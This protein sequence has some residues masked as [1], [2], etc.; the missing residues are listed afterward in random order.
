MPPLFSVNI[1]AR[2]KMEGLVSATAKKVFKKDAKR[3]QDILRQRMGGGGGGRKLCQ[4]KYTVGGFMY[5]TTYHAQ[6][7]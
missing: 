1:L 6:P 7:C 5:S 3:I 4:V 2:G